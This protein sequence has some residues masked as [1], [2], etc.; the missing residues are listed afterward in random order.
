M[1]K[2]G[3]FKNMQQVE[4]YCLGSIVLVLLNDDSDLHFLIPTCA[5]SVI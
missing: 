3:G 5:E 1:F 2:F 4:S